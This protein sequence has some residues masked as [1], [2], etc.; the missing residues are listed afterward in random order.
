MYSKE[1]IVKN[2]TGLHAR[3]ASEFVKE[4][5]KYASKVTICPTDNRKPA[6]NAKSI[7]VLLSMAITQGTAIELS[8]EGPDEREAVEALAALVESGFGEL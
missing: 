2:P 5:K 1:V 3:P 4:A 8:A 7:V 6:S